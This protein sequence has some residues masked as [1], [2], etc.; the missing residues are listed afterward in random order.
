MTSFTLHFGEYIA[1][2]EDPRSSTSVNNV[3]ASQEVLPTGVSKIQVFF[4]FV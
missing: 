3:L 4:F 2:L 1:S